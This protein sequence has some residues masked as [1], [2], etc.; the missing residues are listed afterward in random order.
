[1]S[2]FVSEILETD[3]KHFKVLKEYFRIMIVSVKNKVNFVLVFL[4]ISVQ[5]QRRQVGVNV[6]GV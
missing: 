2:W 6:A 3:L 4:I 1:M 5:N